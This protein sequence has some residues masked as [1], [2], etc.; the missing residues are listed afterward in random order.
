MAGAALIGSAGGALLATRADSGVLKPVVCWRWSR[1][2]P[3]PVRTPP[4][5]PWSSCGCGP[6]R[7]GRSPSSAGAASASTTASSAPARAASW[8]SCSS[9]R[10]GCPSCTPARRPR[11]VNTATNLSA[12]ALF[13]AGGHVLWGLGAA[14]AACNLAGSQVGT[15][16]A[17]RRGSRWVRRVFIVVVSA[18]IV[19]LA[20]DVVL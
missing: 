8:S 1:S 17:I 4:W 18:L 12:L 5:G 13:A 6:G 20:H 10:S 14:M 11:S 16:L 19:R 7:S 9:A 2:S 15:R 3:T